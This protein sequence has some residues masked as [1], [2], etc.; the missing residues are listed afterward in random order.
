MYNL[1]IYIHTTIAISYKNRVMIAYLLLPRQKNDDK[2][3]FD[4][5][6]EEKHTY[7]LFKSGT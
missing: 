6:K 2:T 3:V 5:E 1:Y 7:F 4:F